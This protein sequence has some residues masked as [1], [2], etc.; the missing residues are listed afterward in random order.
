MKR[1]ELIAPGQIPEIA[2]GDDLPNIIADAFQAEHVELCDGDLLV[3]THKIVSKAEGRVYDLRSITPSETAT[4]LASQCG[5]PPSLVE[6]ILRESNCVMR[7]RPGVLIMRHRLGFICANAGVDQ[8]NSGGESWAV[9]LPEHPDQSAKK[10]HDG[11]KQLTKKSIPVLISDS[12]GRPFR[13]GTL[14]IAIGCCG[15]APLR[16]YRGKYDRQG[17]VLQSS[18]EAL[19]DEL[20]CAASLL[21]GQSNESLPVVLVRGAEYQL[22]DHSANLLLRAQEQDLFLN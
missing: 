8:S 10:I 15:L 5:K 17:Y 7:T 20:C 14:G 9:L 11:L 1:L 22:S 18:V 4:A 3:V 6:L 13:N 2:A 19:A 12:Q 16:D 21:M